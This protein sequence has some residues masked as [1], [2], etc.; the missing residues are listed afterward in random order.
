MTYSTRTPDGVRNVHHRDTPGTQRSAAAALATLGTE[1]DQLWPSHRWPPL[2]LDD[3]L[4]P[5]SRGGHGPIRYHVG[6]VDEG[7]SVRFDFDMPDLAGWH[8]LS[9]HEVSTGTLRWTHTLVVH[10][11]SAVV[12]HAVIPLH[13]ALLE[14]LLDRAA[15]LGQEAPLP[16]RRWPL[17]VRTTM[18]AILWAERHDELPPAERAERRPVALAV[19]GTV[20][21]AAAL[22]AVWGAG[23]PW[24]V[25]DRRRLARTVVGTE[26]P[27]PGPLACYA[28]TG[29]LG[30]LAWATA[31][32]VAVR[33]R[34]PP[35]A[36]AA[37][38]GTAGLALTARAT[39][40]A[41]TSV[42][43]PRAV[44]PEYRRLDLAVYSPLCAALAA[45]VVATNRPSSRPRRLSRA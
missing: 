43:R 15:V 23:S 7:R 24:P 31:D 44:T 8:E 26:G 11:P 27:P 36:S 19:A 18:A 6:A 35:V 13:D 3:G 20:A 30:A 22:H 12:R 45:G 33:P 5:G 14:D 17:R 2:L 40:G 38:L 41:A 9:V 1:H 21:A 28:V 10:A 29:L 37:V 25:R 34:V 4:R 32:R 39:V 16:H 42:L